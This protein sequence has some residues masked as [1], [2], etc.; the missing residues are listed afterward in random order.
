[1]PPEGQTQ[2]L[3]PPNSFA[4]LYKDWRRS[5]HFA[6][7]VELWPFGNSLRPQCH[8]RATKSKHVRSWGVGADGKVNVPMRKPL[9]IA[10]SVYQHPAQAGDTD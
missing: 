10:Q 2:A 1:M 8:D 3:W 7:Q 4:N 6:A 5:T 9:L